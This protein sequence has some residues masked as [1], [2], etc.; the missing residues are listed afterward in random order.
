MTLTPPLLAAMAGFKVR[1]RKERV[2]VPKESVLHFAVAKLLREHTLPSWR[3]T[4]IGHGEKRDIK[5]A[6]KLMQLGQ[7][8]GWPDFL[9]ISPTGRVHCLELKRLGGE[10]SF[11]QEEFRI[12]CVAHSVPY[13]VAYTMDHVLLA[14]ERWEC[15]NV[16]FPARRADG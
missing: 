2:P 10:L 6:I 5:T 12:W 4:H 15:L 16:K 7:K 11:N 14:L 9:F 1:Q 8:P 13:E 3:W